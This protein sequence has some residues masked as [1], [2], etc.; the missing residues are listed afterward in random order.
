MRR[1]R[2]I[3]FIFP[4]ILFAL[5]IMLFILGARESP[6]SE[7]N[8]L[9]EAEPVFS[10]ATSSPIPEKSA[11]SPQ[12]ETAPAA[13]KEEPPRQESRVSAEIF[14]I[15]N[16]ETYERMLERNTTL[17]WPIASITKTMTAIIA[18]E[19][20][21]KNQEITIRDGVATSSEAR[22]GLLSGEVFRN[23]DLI[24]A[25]MIGSNNEAAQSIALSDPSFDFVEKM[26]EYAREM[27]MTHTTFVDATGLSR[28]N[29]S[30]ADDLTKLMRYMYESHPELL[31][32]SVATSTTIADLESDK[33]H[34]IENI[35]VFA[36][37]P[38]FLGG[39][40]GYILESKGNLSGFF[41]R[42]GKPILI[43]VLGSSDRF[44]DTQI[45]YDWARQ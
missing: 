23:Q 35:N 16:I 38:G 25:L 7:N 37:K 33:E 12:K 26:N 19:Q 32:M 5:G 11:E 6:V 2:K 21:S 20:L 3:I 28:E 34:R 41:L 18:E 27:G 14:L 15:E 13:K 22:G 44:K 36:G 30:T 9:R 40:T 29:V 31:A 1:P 42:R 43:I 8:Y 24:K 45:L 17:P 4:S 39:K 10:E